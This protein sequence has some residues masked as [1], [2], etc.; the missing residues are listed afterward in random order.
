MK[1]VEHYEGSNISA[2]KTFDTYD[3]A[4]A[5]WEERKSFY[6]LSKYTVEEFTEGQ[7]WLN[8]I[9]KYG[10]TGL[11]IAYFEAFKESGDFKP[12]ADYEE[13]AKEMFPDQKPMYNL[14]D[15]DDD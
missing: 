6:E 15:G 13:V 4:K 1:M 9:T 2:S 8:T 5:W 10:N 7:D 12:L 14:D 3:E 11:F